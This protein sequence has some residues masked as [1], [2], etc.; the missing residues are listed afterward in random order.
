MEGDRCKA[1][2]MP[3][4]VALNAE[5]KICQVIGK[6]QGEYLWITFVFFLASVGY[7]CYA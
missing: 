3:E 2:L 4:I 7:F 1:K 6:V 5:H